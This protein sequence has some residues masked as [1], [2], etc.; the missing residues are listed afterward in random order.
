MDTSI[1][2][3]VQWHRNMIALAGG[4]RRG[5]DVLAQLQVFLLSIVDA[6]YAEQVPSYTREK[7]AGDCSCWQKT[8]SS[9]GSNS[10]KFT[11]LYMI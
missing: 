9:R 2:L 8:K 11:G 10:I 6:M 3:G 4:A 1:L 5:I 7:T